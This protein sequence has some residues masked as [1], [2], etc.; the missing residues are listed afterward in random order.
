MSRFRVSLPLLDKKFEGRSSEIVEDG[1]PVSAICNY[2]DFRSLCVKGILARKPPVSC[3]VYEHWITPKSQKDLQ[4]VVKFCCETKCVERQSW[5]FDP[6][7]HDS[8]YCKNACPVSGFILNRKQH[9]I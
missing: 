7:P 4:S 6:V 3:C 9:E 1:A 2:C 5:D 8:D